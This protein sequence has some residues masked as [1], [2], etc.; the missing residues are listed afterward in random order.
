MTSS[1]HHVHVYLVAGGSGW[2][3][4][5]ELLVHGA[6]AW[7]YAGPL[8]HA[9]SGGLQ[10]V[11]IDNQVISTGEFISIDVSKCGNYIHTG[12]Y[13]NGRERENGKILA[14]IFKFDPA[15][16]SWRQVGEMAQ[17]R[18]Y[19]AASVVRPEEVSS[20]V[21]KYLIYYKTKIFDAQLRKKHG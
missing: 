13:G 10:V 8:P 2:S 20:S 19:H 12:G 16:L 17:A 18:A 14:T 21:Y 15:T 5:T 11:S 1:P 6:S 4:T 7:T 9:T 3:Y